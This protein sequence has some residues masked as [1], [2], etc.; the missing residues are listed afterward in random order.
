MYALVNPHVAVAVLAAVAA[1]IIGRA[2][3]RCTTI[4]VIRHGAIVD[5]IATYSQGRGNLGSRV[6][7]RPPNHDIGWADNV[8][9]PPNIFGYTI[10]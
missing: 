10:I 3:Y 6:G 2:L 7:S 1:A 9:C 4:F 8:F 5:N